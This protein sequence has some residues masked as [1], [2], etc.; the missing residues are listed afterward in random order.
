MRWIQLISHLKPGNLPNFRENRGGPFKFQQFKQICSGTTKKNLGFGPIFCII[1]LNTTQIFLIKRWLFS[2]LDF[3]AK[4]PKKASRG[5]H[6]GN[7]F[8]ILDGIKHSPKNFSILY[9]IILK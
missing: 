9:F 7:K 1:E 5:P 8:C 3:G 6:E 4:K 2:F